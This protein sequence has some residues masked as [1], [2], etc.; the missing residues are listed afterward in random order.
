V[1]KEFFDEKLRKTA[2]IAFFKLFLWKISENGE[3]FIWKISKIDY[4]FL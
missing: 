2:K 1:K 4:I 3:L